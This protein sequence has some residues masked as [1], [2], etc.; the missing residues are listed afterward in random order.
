VKSRNVRG[1]TKM[2]LFA[3]SSRDEQVLLSSNDRASYAYRGEAEQGR[4][5]A[6]KKFYV[7]AKILKDQVL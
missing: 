7:L 5:I 3:N 1:E 4:R 2:K 6:H